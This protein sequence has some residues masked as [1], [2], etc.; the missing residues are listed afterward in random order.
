VAETQAGKGSMAPGATRA[1]GAV[2][3]TGTLAANRIARD[4][5]LVVGVGTRW[6]DFTTASKTAFRAEGVT[7]VNVNLAPLDLA[8][9]AGLAVDADAL[10]ALEALDA[11]LDGHRVA[12]DYAAEIARLVAEWAGEVERQTA[13]RAGVA[14]TQAE[15]IAAVNDRVRDEDVMVAAAGSV[16]GDVHKLW[17]SR[18]PGDYHVEYG[19]STMGYEIAGALGVKLAAPEREVFVLV[20][21]GSYLMLSSEIATAVQEGL[22]LVIVLIDNRGFA[23]IGGLS[24]SVGTAGFGTRYRRRGG[25]GP[26]LDGEGEDALRL[27]PVDLAANAA[28]LGTEVLRAGDAAQL[29]DALTRAREAEGVVVVAVETDRYAGV[30]SYE[31][32]WDVPVAEVSERGAVR[33][34]R[35]AYEQAREAQRMYLRTARD[36]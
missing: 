4:A 24:R 35:A 25:G 36:G 13:P 31:S 1:L 7:F 21:D 12:D 28:S 2:G 34:A 11:A 27:L 14:L 10:V 9:H 18:R 30:P 16:P 20:G 3:A 23:S 32:W 17:R 22:K 29:R 15:V 33:E 8:K 26:S 6:T 5:D 19:Y